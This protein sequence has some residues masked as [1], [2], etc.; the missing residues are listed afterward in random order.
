MCKLAIWTHIHSCSISELF[1]SDFP[2]PP[3][4][5]YYFIRPPPHPIP[6]ATFYFFLK[7]ITQ[8]PSHM[9]WWMA[10][11]GHKQPT[12]K[13]LYVSSSST[14]T[15]SEWYFEMPLLCDFQSYLRNVR[16]QCNA[17][18]FDSIQFNFRPNTGRYQ[19][20]RQATDNDQPA[21]DRR[22]M[23]DRG[24]ILN[25]A[26]YHGL[27][28]HTQSLPGCLLLPC[29]AFDWIAL[30]WD[31]GLG[32]TKRYMLSPERVSEWVTVIYCDIL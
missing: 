12:A 16:I 24:A 3:W 28:I 23:R 6:S 19:F 4:F 11:D 26:H 21:A 8:P 15:T 29:T 17:G 5:I 18:E 7:R 32:T 20:S 1:Y 9:Q 2:F 10:I 13:E 30:A 22:T 27:I 25:G 14:T 31:S